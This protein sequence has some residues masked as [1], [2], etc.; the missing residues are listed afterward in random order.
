[1]TDLNLNS[2]IYATYG[3]KDNRHQLIH[4][5]NPEVQLPSQ[6]LSITDKPAGYLPANVVW[7]PVFGCAVYDNYWCLWCTYS[8]YEASRGGMVISK[9]ALLPVNQAIKVNDLTDILISIM[10]S[11][12][13][14]EMTDEQL[15]NVFNSLVLAT[16]PVLILED[17]ASFATII[18]ELWKGLWPEA[19]KRLV[20]NVKWGPSQ[21]MAGDN[22]FNV[23]A[24]IASNKLRWNESYTAIS[25]DDN[26]NE[27]MSNRAVKFLLDHQDTILENFLENTLLAIEKP[28]LQR[29]RKLSRTVE[30]IENFNIEP[31]VSL[32][33]NLIRNSLSYED[34]EGELDIYVNKAL[35]YLA[36][37]LA[38]LSFTEVEKIQNIVFK[39]NHN[40]NL[41]C[42]SLESYIENKFTLLK[43]EDKNRLIVDAINK[44]DKWWYKAL[45]KGVAKG[46]DT[47]SP[48]WLQQA[49]QLILS[50]DL[51]SIANDVISDSKDIEKGILELTLENEPNDKGIK[52]L[53]E[54]ARSKNWSKLYAWCLFK[55]EQPIMALNKVLDFEHP[56]V[57]GFD[58]LAELYSENELLNTFRVINDTRLISNIENTNAFVEKL[59]PYL[60]LDKEF[61]RYLLSQGYRNE[62][63]VPSKI[64]NN[65]GIDFILRNATSGNETYG[66]IGLLA[67]KGFEEDLAKRALLQLNE[68]FIWDKLSKSDTEVL[69]NTISHYVIENGISSV[70]DKTI[71]ENIKEKF[72]KSEIAPKVM[73]LLIGWS[74]HVNESEVINILGQYTDNN[75]RQYG[76]NLGEFINSNKWILITKA[77][78]TLYGNKQIVN[79]A[80]KY[81]YSLLPKKQKWAYLFK[82]KMKLD[83]LP[84]DYLISRLVD[85]ASSLY[86]SEELE[87]L[88]EKAGGKLK[89]LNSNGN[90]GKQWTKAIK[91]AKKGNIEGG[92]LTLIDIMLERYPHNTELNELKTFF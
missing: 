65:T 20:C 1:M 42:L 68:S 32:A 14:P 76:K 33:I 40:Y 78:Y 28:P 45:K 11:D 57:V 87:L 50:K 49:K 61:D 23:V 6:L 86:G 2:L 18:N 10:S 71:Q 17:L 9:V 22:E 27:V 30:L 3:A 62:L 60:E 16:H 36:E 67:E 38:S 15:K 35:I 56:E 89:D 26:N 77:L 75:W 69:I 46:I 51:S 85:E 81:C 44:A 91:K 39:K 5:T 83:E 43:D 55:L 41:L 92:V 24:S 90:L 63:L 52:R 48:N 8:D 21:T 53:K 66:L 79:N 80:L 54:F 64:I 29:L 70:T 19:R 59:L 34:T 73:D 82:S 31:S 4:T 88:W 12:K 47:L 74:F 7:Y 84:D 37:N 58:Y 72:L 13:L 25:A